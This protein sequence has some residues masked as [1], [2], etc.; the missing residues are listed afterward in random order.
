MQRSQLGLIFIVAGFLEF[1]IAL[2]ILLTI[3]F[4][5]IVSLFIMF[6]SVIEIAVGFA[7]AKGVEHSLDIPSDDCYYCKGTGKVDNETCPRCGGSGL[8]RADD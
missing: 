5:Y 1:I 3:S 2:I 6:V 8:A 7:Y 4:L